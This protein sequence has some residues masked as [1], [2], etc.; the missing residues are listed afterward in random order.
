MR[1]DSEI[2]KTKA[3]RWLEC[4]LL[5]LCLCVLALRATYAE[6]PHI[7]QLTTSNQILG[8]DGF[9]LVIS[10]VL[11]AAAIVWC[12]GIFL[13]RRSSY[14][15]S[16]IEIGLALFLIA[17][18]IGIWVAS[19]KRAAITDMVT[20]VAPMLMA[21]L[22][23]QILDSAAKIKLVLFVVVAL[24]AAGAFQCFDQL[25][26]S[27]QYMIE[28]YERDPA[29]HITRAGFEP[30]SF[31]HMLYEHRLYSKDIRGFFTTGNSA[32]S[33]AILATFAAA[34]LVIEN[35]RRRNKET[36]YAPLVYCSIA[37]AVVTAG[38]V[39]THSKGAIIASVISAAFLAAY[40]MFGD[41]LFVN[42]KTVF[43]L[44]LSAVVAGLAALVWYGTSH[45][46]LPGG[47]SMMV[48]WQY[49]ASAMKM[50]ADKPLTGVGGG[51]FATFYTHYKP[52][53]ALESVRD[54][55]NFVLTVLTQYGPLGL[56]GFVT[57]FG[58]VLYKTIFAATTSGSPE[59]PADDKPFGTLAGATLVFV[60]VTLLVFRPVLMA[61]E[62]GEGFMVIVSV[63]LMLYVVVAISFSLA[64]LVL[65]LSQEKSGPAKRSVGTATQ[66]AVF[67]GVIG[68]I[69]HNLIDFAIFEPGVLTCFWAM[70]ACLVAAGFQSSRPAASPAASETRL[71]GQ[72]YGYRTFVFRPGFSIRIIAIA[73]GIAVFWAYCSYAFV[74]AIKASGKTQQ[75]LRNPSQAAHFFAAAS[76]DDRF[77]PAA[78]NLNG[79]LHLQ[80]YLHVPARQATMLT[81]AVQYFTEASRRDPADFQ[82][83]ERLMV[84]YELL[85]MASTSE[86][87]LEWTKKA[88]DSGLEAARRYPGKGMLQFELGKIAERLG[89]KNTA[90]IHYE[91]AVQIED[92]YRAQFRQMY[93]G[94]E[95]FS[96]LGQSRYEEAKKRIARLCN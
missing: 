61:D 34:G 25:L 86:Q 94:R 10:T 7:V 68:V 81:Q 21:L 90:L 44:F 95:M 84:V 24:G 77:S 88:Y 9:S 60:V 93:P 38:L 80:R 73:A 18:F 92:S 45:G 4:A 91:K 71:D 66:A 30:N 67:C 22:L 32:G 6:N 19:N 26:S 33:F 48:R 15:F 42:K 23:V 69:I 72:R 62:I 87:S 57:A 16:G 59:R 2:S 76:A 64:F 47:N 12:L 58:F 37:A 14:R 52:P 35:F 13:C 17:G 40:L 70:I 78:L 74:P 56:L 11:I 65:W 96:R 89:N 31:Q 50:Y 39:V 1:L 29:D 85:A 20:L 55:H 83:Y 3:I 63:A 54:P 43:V 36:S 49:W 28:D 79:R 27:N 46:Y 51:N 8:N 5:I 75:A 53:Q 41:W 82:S